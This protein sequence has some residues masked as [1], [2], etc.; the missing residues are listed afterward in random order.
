MTRVQG[1]R[2]PRR[3]K[4]AAKA[5]GHR[6]PTLPRLDKTLEDNPEV[7]TP[8]LSKNFQGVATEAKKTTVDT[9]H[10]RTA[11]QRRTTSRRRQQVP[12][13]ALPHSAAGYSPGG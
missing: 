3:E 10:T 1:R 12:S 9:F 13:G 8:D 11:F 6:Q 4:E 7:P 2:Q 5:E